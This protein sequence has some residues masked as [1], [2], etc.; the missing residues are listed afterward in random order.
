MPIVKLPVSLQKFTQEELVGVD[1]DTIQQS[2]SNL[3]QLYPELAIHLFSE[4]SISPFLGV[5]LNNK[6]TRNPLASTQQLT[7]EDVISIVMAV[8][9]G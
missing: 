7:N 8:S 2:L 4:N 5:F 3:M 6:L 9:G 1:G